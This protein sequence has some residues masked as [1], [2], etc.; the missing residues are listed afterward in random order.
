[1]ARNHCLTIARNTHTPDTFICTGR[2]IIFIECVCECSFLNNIIQFFCVMHG[3][4]G[5]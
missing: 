1:M 3:I 5:K 2:T 4:D